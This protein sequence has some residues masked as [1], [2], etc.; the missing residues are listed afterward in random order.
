[1]NNKITIKD[2]ND[3]GLSYIERCYIATINGLDENE[4]EEDIY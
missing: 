3:S 1:M 2:I 4:V